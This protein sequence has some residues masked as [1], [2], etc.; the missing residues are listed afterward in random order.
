MLDK[1]LYHCLCYLSQLG[2]LCHDILSARSLQ[3][4]MH[5]MFA[6][7]VQQGQAEQATEAYKE[8]SQRDAA[9]TTPNDHADLKQYHLTKPELPT[10]TDPDVMALM[11]LL[12]IL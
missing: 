9:D 2:I 12:R 11:A 4:L 5:V 6:Q 8:R 10:Q 3:Q 1:E 7:G